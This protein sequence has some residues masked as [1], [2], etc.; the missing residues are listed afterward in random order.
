[1]K[2]IQGNQNTEPASPPYPDHPAIGFY[3]RISTGAWPSNWEEL[4]TRPSV[5]WTHL[6]LYLA[7]CGFADLLT[8]S[9]LREEIAVWAPADFLANMQRRAT[10]DALRSL[11]HAHALTQLHDALHAQGTRAILLKGAA[12]YLLEKAHGHPPA[13]IPGDI[14]IWVESPAAASALRRKLLD[15][16]FSGDST[17]RRTAPHHLAPV[18]CRNSA[19]EIHIAT[20]PSFWGLP[21]T[22]FAARAIPIAGWPA[23]FALH[24]TDMILHEAVHCTSHLWSFG[25]K[26]AHDIARIQQLAARPAIA[27]A[28]S[29][30]APQ[31]EWALLPQLAEST[32]CPQAFWA[33]ILSLQTMLTPLLPF[34]EPLMIHAPCTRASVRAT[35]V[36]RRRMF[37]PVEDADTLNPFVRNA[38]FL[39]LFKGQ[40]T[41]YL[42]ELLSGSAAES[43]QT[44][45]TSG[46][47]QGWKEL[48]THLL[49]ACKE[50]LIRRR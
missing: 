25:L 1:M 47:G 22:G 5:D 26:L 39:S 40:R 21:D 19:V 11:S 50:L 41:R 30:P 15:T 46:G 29:E 27:Q 9:P 31:I 32:H 24:P 35:N 36:A 45:L 6:E 3:H 42:H 14:D 2:S 12:L 44:A 37:Q 38:V 33:P 10:A 8:R 7:A 4:V 23:F 34:P 17:A 49:S 28:N 18:T 48:P 43:R 20:M 16:G 13:R